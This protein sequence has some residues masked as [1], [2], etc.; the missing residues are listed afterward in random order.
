MVKWSG[1]GESPLNNYLMRKKQGPQ[2]WVLRVSKS[3][4]TG[5]TVIGKSYGG[6]QKKKR[7]SPT[8]S[9][10]TTKRS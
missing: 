4:A 8:W 9:Y 10:P 5:N 3:K 2:T 1:E 6:H 7:G